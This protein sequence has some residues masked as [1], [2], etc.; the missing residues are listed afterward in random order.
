MEYDRFKEC[1]F[2]PQINSISDFE[3]RQKAY[4]GNLNEQVKGMDQ[5]LKKKEY[6]K[7]LVQDKQVREQEVFDFASKYDR[8][9]TREK[10]TVPL[11]FKLS[12]APNKFKEKYL[13]PELKPEVKRNLTNEGKKLETIKQ[14]L[15]NQGEDK[16]VY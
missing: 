9:K 14:Y 12:K 13:K 8:K 11:P 7:K 16:Y 15:E 1:T 3:E 10:T 2:K 5:F 6:E 4:K